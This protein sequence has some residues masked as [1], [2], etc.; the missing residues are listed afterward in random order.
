MATIDPLAVPMTSGRPC[1]AER[2]KVLVSARSMSEVVGGFTHDVHAVRVVFAVD[3]HRTSLLPEL[4]RLGAKAV[5]VLASASQK[6]VAGALTAAMPD[7]RAQPLA[8]KRSRSAA[9]QISRAYEVAVREQAD[10][11]VA[12]GSGAVIHA[13]RQ[14]ALRAEVPLV[15]L[16]TSYAGAEFVAP[17]ETP[18]GST[19][20]AAYSS[21]AA[22]RVVIYDPALTV[23]LPDHVT[24]RSA[25]RALA[26]GVDVLCTPDAS[27]V[28]AMMAEEGIRQIAD[29]MPDA[30]LHPHGLVGRSR[31]QYGGYLTAASFAVTAP[32]SHRTLGEAVERACGLR[33]ADVRPVVLPHLLAATGV[34]RPLA[35]ARVAE[36]LGCNDA[37]QGIADLA[38][39]VGAPQSLRELG[40]E[41]DGLDAAL[42][43]LR[44]DETVVRDTE[45]EPDVL[46]AVVESAF[47]GRPPLGP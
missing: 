41:L 34:K 30:I 14:A 8:F 35:L 13:A 17:P 3:A 36:A 31:T 45:L 2:K 24:A 38:H 28:A 7:G 33:H 11:L 32:G 1:D 26:H 46:A 12:V 5:L 42:E 29:G 19:G 10:C 6:A 40:M 16:P 23:G 47:H 4:E 21:A 20:P 9:G 22:S 15:A 39:E 25:M 18:P 27:P 43:A 37:V 44:R